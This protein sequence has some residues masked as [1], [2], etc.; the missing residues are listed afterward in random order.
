M[1]RISI[2][3]LLLTHTVVA[4]A[5]PGHE[6]SNPITPFIYLLWAFVSIVMAGFVIRHLTHRYKRMQYIKNG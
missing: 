4:Y 1:L 6:H 3:L 5:H 2:L